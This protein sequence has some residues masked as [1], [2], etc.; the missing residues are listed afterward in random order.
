MSTGSKST[1]RATN[2]MLD[3]CFFLDKLEAVPAIWTNA[4]RHQVRASDA[5]ISKAPD[6]ELWCTT[7][8]SDSLAVQRGL[9]RIVSKQARFHTCRSRFGQSFLLQRRTPSCTVRIPVKHQLRF[10]PRRVF[11][12]S[13]QTKNQV[14]AMVEDLCIESSKC[15]QHQPQP[16][17][18]K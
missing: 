8:L 10:G 3:L 9:M 16:S 7:L 17:Q 6:R 5:T 15:D 11:D 13:L 2:A 18:A 4:S 12:Q 1:K 14:I